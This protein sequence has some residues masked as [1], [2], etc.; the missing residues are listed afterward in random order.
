MTVNRHVLY[1]PSFNINLKEKHMENT[2][3]LCPV[4]KKCG[5]CQLSNMDYPRQLA[6]KQARCEM[7]LKKFCR[8]SPI[9]GMD[10]PYHYRNKVQAAFGK[11]RGGKI[12]SGVYQSKTGNIVSL[13]RCMTE[14]ECADRIIVDIRK[15]LPG[16][17]LTVYDEINGTG[18]L[19][20]VLI[21]RGF[22]S[23]QVMVVLV[24]ANNNFRS[25]RSFVNEL[26]R[27]HPEITTVVMN[28]NRSKTGLFLGDAEEVLYGDGYIEDTLCGRVFRI[29][30]K[31]FYQINPVQTEKLYSIAIE[32]AALTPESKVLDA[33]CGIGTIGLVAAKD[34][35]QVVGVELNADAVRDAKANAKLNGVK[36]VSFY[37]AD[38]GDFICRAAEKGEKYDVIF[39]DPPRAGSTKKFIDAIGVCS[40][41]RIVYVSCN[42]ETL[43]RDLHFIV[44]KGYTVT[45]ITPVDMFPHTKHVETVCCL[46]RITHIAP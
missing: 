10:E 42:P 43:E 40:P 18:L 9:V 19:R 29:S 25:K 2:K 38:A 7:L 22:T 41:K 34:A 35:G 21:K 16:F 39:M 46:Q 33:Y 23:G 11:T 4:A 31:S 27:R 45:H 3:S 6:W 37:C 8:V 14:D 17:K 28:V 32:Y 30:P 26:V 20:H 12:I 15:M 36:N 13:D 24:V 1:S 5:A 44:K